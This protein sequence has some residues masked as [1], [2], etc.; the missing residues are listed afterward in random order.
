M[1]YIGMTSTTFKERLGNHNYTFEHKEHSVQQIMKYI[2]NVI[3]IL[4]YINS[5]SNNT[6]SASVMLI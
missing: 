6:S 4:F 5:T 1:N 2:L 3:N